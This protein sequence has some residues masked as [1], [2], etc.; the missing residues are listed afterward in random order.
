MKPRTYREYT[1]NK[2]HLTELTR[3]EAG[4][5]ELRV[6][7]TKQALIEGIHPALTTYLTSLRTLIAQ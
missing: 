3:R 5:L 1:S 7:H 6:M 4:I 2:Y